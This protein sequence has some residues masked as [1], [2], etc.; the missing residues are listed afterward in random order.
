MKGMQ[1]YDVDLFDTTTAQIAEYKK[2]GKKVVCYF[3]AGS[4]EDWRND[5]ANF[6]KACYCN[7]GN[8]CK[9]DGWDEYVS[10]HDLQIRRKK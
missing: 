5:A 6:N 10:L 3:S 1:V 2:Q 4:F 7:K 8:E 9:M